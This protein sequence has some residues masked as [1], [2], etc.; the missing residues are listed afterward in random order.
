VLKT[1][2]IITDHPEEQV[3]PDELLPGELKHQANSLGQ[4]QEA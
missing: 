2:I 4:L 1:P 3:R